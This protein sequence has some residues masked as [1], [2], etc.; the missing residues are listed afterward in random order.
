MDVRSSF[1]TKLYLESTR[2]SKLINIFM[3][4]RLISKSIK[5]KEDLILGDLNFDTNLVKW[6]LHI[7][8]VKRFGIL[9]GPNIVPL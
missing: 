9:F 1:D 8:F 5:K 6:R 2:L 7:Q 4:L 3:D